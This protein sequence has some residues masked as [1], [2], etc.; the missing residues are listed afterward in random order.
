MV[1]RFCTLDEKLVSYI[2]CIRKEQLS[3]SE[4]QALQNHVSKGQSES[5]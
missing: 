4:T 2:T 3:E 1:V 5:R